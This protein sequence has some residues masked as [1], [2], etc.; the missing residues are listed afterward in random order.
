MRPLDRQ[1]RSH[2]MHLF[3]TH[4]FH[5]RTDLGQNFLIDLNIIDF[6]VRQ[7]DLGPQD[8]VLEIGAGT[9]GM[10]TFL[11]HEA[12]AV[13]SVEIDRRMHGLASEALAGSG[14]KNVTLLNCDALKNKNRFAVEVVDAIEQQLAAEPQRRLKLVANLPYCIA[15]P[16]ISNLVATEW[17]WVLMVATIQWELAERMRAA[18]GTHDYGSLSVWLQSQCAVSLLKKLGPTVFWPRPNVESAVVRLAPDSERR[19]AIAD[20]QFFHD[21]IRRLFHQRRKAARNVLTGMYRKQL[22]KPAIDDVLQGIA[23]KPG[24]RAEDCDVATLVRLADGLHKA[25]G[26][27]IG[28]A[29]EDAND[30]ANSGIE[31][32]DCRMT[33]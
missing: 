17:P 10:T 15:T 2:L 18:P 11:A 33:D 25:M 13:V 31:G 26:P 28:L 8:V 14:C 7:A 30:D 16:V 5:P 27:L 12:A 6:V 4:G 19:G 1:T 29:G 9:G 24:F 3:Q 32:L 21:F 22:S 23:L 20:R